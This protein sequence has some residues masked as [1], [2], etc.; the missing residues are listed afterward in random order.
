[1]GGNALKNTETERKSTKQLYDIYSKIKESL[2]KELNTKTF[3]PEFFRNKQTHGDLDILVLNNGDKKFNDINN[4]IT[5]LFSPN[6]IINNKTISFDYDKCQIDLM[7]IS[8][9]D[10]YT[11]QFYYTFSPLANLMGRL[12]K[13]LRFEYKRYRITFH[14]GEMGFFAKVNDPNGKLQGKILISKNIK[15]MFNIL[16]L[17]YNIFKKGFDSQEDI[18]D[19]IISSKYFNKDL[20]SLDKIDGKT[21][22]RNQN[23]PE[24]MK[25]LD[26]IDGVGDR[27]NFDLSE[28]DKINLIENTIDDVNLKERI[29][30]I[31][32]KDRIY[33]VMKSK[34]NGD[35][36][37]KLFP[38]LSGDKLG[39][40]IGGFKKHI[41]NTYMTFDEYLLN[42]SSD[43]IINDI[44][45]FYNEKFKR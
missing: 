44:K 41:T 9:K 1:M 4:I 45:M 26:Y 30:R 31:I 29:D 34:F 10:W 42:K 37:M 38:D 7:L 6:E 24:Y 22:K 36:I 20:F 40:F 27:Y 13:F 33:K 11:S 14:I 39:N 5:K 32:N 23:R 2:E 19:F 35:I 15:D 3:V 28:D 8:G 16:S 25:F 43:D 21:R 12:I 17:D 18:F